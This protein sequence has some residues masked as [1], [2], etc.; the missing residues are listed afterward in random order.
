M[1]ILLENVV[2][3][4]LNINFLSFVKIILY[5]MLILEKLI[6]L[7]NYSEV[8]FAVFCLA[9]LLLKSKT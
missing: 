7:R 3:L 1:Y 2:N 8:F 5:I 4:K 6:A 9:W